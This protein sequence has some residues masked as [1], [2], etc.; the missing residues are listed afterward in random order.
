MVYI[1]KLKKTFWLKAGRERNFLLYVG[2]IRHCTKR[3]FVGFSSYL[4]RRIG[5]HKAVSTDVRHPIN[6]FATRAEVLFL[7][8]SVLDASWSS[9]AT[10]KL[11]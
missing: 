10:G 5:C 11:K 1:S 8:F 9:P 6:N 4:E 3:L 7:V 2:P